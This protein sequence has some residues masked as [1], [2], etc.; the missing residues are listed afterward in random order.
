M[1]LFMQA[2]DKIT[3]HDKETIKFFENSSVSCVQ[4]PRLVP[5]VINELKNSHYPL[6]KIESLFSGIQYMVISLIERE[7]E[8]EIVNRYLK[9]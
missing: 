2:A 3:T 7:R 6:T 9:L 4:A 5:A 8:R 1:K